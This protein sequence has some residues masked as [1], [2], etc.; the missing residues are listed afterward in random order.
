MLLMVAR[1]LPFASWADDP[2]LQL[3]MPLLPSV[4]LFQG[5]FKVQSLVVSPRLPFPFASALTC[6]RSTVETATQALPRE[7]VPEHRCKEVVDVNSFAVVASKPPL[8]IAIDAGQAIAIVR[9]PLIR[10]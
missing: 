2:L 4:T 3:K 5:H 10:V 7:A 8:A 6:A 1:D 9:S